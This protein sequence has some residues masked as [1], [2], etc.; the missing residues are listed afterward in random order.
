MSVIRSYGPNHLFMAILCARVDALPRNSI[1]NS[2]MSMQSNFSAGL[3]GAEARAD[4]LAN[5]AAAYS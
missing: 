3:N 1:S 5:F 2:A 4:L